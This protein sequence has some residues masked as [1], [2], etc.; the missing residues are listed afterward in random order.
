V[1]AAVT[2]GLLFR[3]ADQADGRRPRLVLTPAGR[4]RVETVRRF[5][6]ERFAAATESW[7]DSE[8]AAFADLLTRFVAGLDRSTASR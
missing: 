7:T 1:A 6:R 5:R 4:A 3:E 2:D 8:R